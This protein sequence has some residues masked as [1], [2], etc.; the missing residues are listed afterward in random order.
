[1]TIIII[2]IT[3]NIQPVGQRNGDP[4]KT[5][6]LLLWGKKNPFPETRRELT[7]KSLFPLILSSFFPSPDR[8]VMS[9][10][11][12]DLLFYLLSFFNVKNPFQSPISK[13]ELDINN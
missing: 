1:M 10:W 12:Q 6:H 11:V 13:F 7:E 3:G 2:M 5:T 8:L 9:L 4:T